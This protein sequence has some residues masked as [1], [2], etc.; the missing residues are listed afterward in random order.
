VISI[1]DIS[2]GY[3][4]FTPDAKESGLAYAS[5]TFQ[6]ADQS[7]LLDGSPNTLTVDVVNM[8]SV[9][10]L[11]RR[12]LSNE[13]FEANKKVEELFRLRAVNE[14]PKDAYQIPRSNNIKLDSAH[15]KPGGRDALLFS[16]TSRATT[17][18]VP[19]TER[20]DG[21]K[22]GTRLRS[23]L[24]PPDPVT[25]SHGRI[26]YQLPE[27]VCKGGLGVIKY[28]ATQKDGSPLPAWI[29]FDSLTG[30]LIAEVPKEMKAPLEV[31]VEAVDS[32]GFKAETTFKILPRP[33][34]PSFEG[35]RSLSAQFNSAF[36]LAR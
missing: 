33:S 30:K 3:L 24:T 35:K 23:M 18:E 22:P 25:D 11:S 7:R 1:D 21:T 4:T 17:Q 6:V 34:K 20:L 13:G 15:P 16:V 2:G 19:G 10:A 12:D 29:Q 5:F 32:R 27:G 26:A 8:N 9:T 14:A 28:V 31:K 36:S